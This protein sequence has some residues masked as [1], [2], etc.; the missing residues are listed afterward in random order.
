MATYANVCITANRAAARKQFSLQGI[1]PLLANGGH[2]YMVTTYAL[3][4]GRATVVGRVVNPK[5]MVVA[6]RVR[7]PSG[8]VC[9][10]PP[11]LMA[12][13]CVYVPGTMATALGYPKA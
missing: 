4:G 10:M 9:N 8:I 3:P 6:Y 13:G 7:L 5:G 2:G 12:I 1:K 11:S